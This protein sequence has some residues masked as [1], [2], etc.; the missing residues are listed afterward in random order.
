MK[1]RRKSLLKLNFVFSVFL[2][3]ILLFLFYNYFLKDMDS[4]KVK[5]TSEKTAI[6]REA[7]F[8]TYLRTPISNE[9][10]ADRL[11]YFYFSGDDSLIKDETDKIIKEIY[12]ESKK[13]KIEVGE[14]SFSN[15]VSITSSPKTFDINLPLFDDSTK[16]EILV[17]LNLYD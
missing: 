14:K 7:F 1:F 8:L 2:I 4:I 3:L 5:I 11:I 15:Y 12:G 13:W 10:M 17:R 9:T 6:D 16:N